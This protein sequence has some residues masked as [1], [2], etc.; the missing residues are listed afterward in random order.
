M[1]TTLALF[2]LAF[3]A[4]FMV[5]FFLFKHRILLLLLIVFIG[6][7]VA[8]RSYSHSKN[9]PAINSPPT[10]PPYQLIAPDKKAAPYIL[11][12]SSR[13]YYVEQYSDN[14]Q[15]ITLKRYFIYD[16]KAWVERNRPLILD[17]AVL[18]KIEVRKR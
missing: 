16:R 12:T 15:V 10:P 17:R 9:E 14:K 2:I 4:P 18:G 6:G 7:I 3:K 13:V 8:W 11:A 5:L 1:K